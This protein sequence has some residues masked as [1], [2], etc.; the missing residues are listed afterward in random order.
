MT[1]DI[2]K[3]LRAA[4]GTMAI[5]TLL[6]M[7]DEAAR[8]IE[9][10]RTE[11]AKRDAEIVELAARD[12]EHMDLTVDMTR[13]EAVP[14][15]EHVTPTLIDRVATAIH[16]GRMSAAAKYGIEPGDDLEAI[17]RKIRRWP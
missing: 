6:D 12:P 13:K 8:I 14:I 7:C 10:Q 17:R 4:D 11:L 5:T 16:E 15:V 3:R 2:V 9:M 1:D